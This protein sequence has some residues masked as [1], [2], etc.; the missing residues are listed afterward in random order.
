MTGAAEF[1]V[2][3]HKGLP[4]RLANGAGMTLSCKP[5][6]CTLQAGH[7]LELELQHL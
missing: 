7:F 3:A 2:W 6:N 1:A 4:S 5:Q